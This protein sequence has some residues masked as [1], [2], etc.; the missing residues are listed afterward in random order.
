M[1][2]SV[3][4]GQRVD[5]TKS[6]PGLD[7]IS[8][9]LGWTCE[10][11]ANINIEVDGAAFLLDSQGKCLHDGLM[12]FYGQQQGLQGAIVHQN[13]SPVD[14][15][16]FQIHLKQI[17]GTVERIAFTITIHEAEQRRQ[18]FANVSNIYI[19]VMNGQNGG[20]ILR[21]PV[22]PFQR[23]TAIVVGELYRHKGEWKFNAIG[24]GY[25]G[26]LAALCNSYGLE[27][28]DK[29][30]PPPP[31]KPTP[32]PPPTPKPR[33]TPPPTPQN[34]PSP[35]PTEERISLSKI[36]LKKKGDR[37]NLEKR[38]GQ[39][40]GHL[41]VNLNWNQRGG[42]P[43]ETGFFKSLFGGASSQGIDLDL[44]CLFELKNGK[45]GAIQ[46][47]GNSFGSLQQEPFIMLDKDDR[48]GASTEGENLLI[49]GIKVREFKR[50]LI[51]AF[52]YEGIT[53]WAQADG[54][55]TIKPQTG[56]E[57]VVRMDDHSQSQGM[58]AIALLENVNNETFSVEKIVRF[59]KGHQDMDRAFGWNMKWVAGS[60][61]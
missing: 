8:V 39:S 5:V 60:K 46:A 12:I 28:I 38:Q 45:K 40:L 1:S 27:V 37:I 11:M 36:E 10:K 14:K 32:P 42:A 20:E 6:Y 21:F 41:V 7:K 53:N 56:A 50:I 26:G 61:D 24:A 43:K 4:K 15:E 18:S 17:P 51:Y 54:V 58:C 30:S 57:I 59:F 23:E 49:N 3:Q 25:H 34:N 48:T 47:L 19:R 29:P 55:V 2:Q 33:P 16:N 13:A 31:P 52:I 35:V 22:G 44:G 9:G